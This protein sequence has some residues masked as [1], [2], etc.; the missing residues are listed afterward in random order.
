MRK[1]KLLLWHLGLYPDSCPYCGSNLI[2][3]GFAGDNQRWTCSTEGCEFNGE[4]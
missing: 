3:H 2:R 4:C 1:V